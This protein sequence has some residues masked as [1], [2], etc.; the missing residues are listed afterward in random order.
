MYVNI[1]YLCVHAEDPDYKDARLFTDGSNALNFM[2]SKGDE[3]KDWSIHILQIKDRYSCM[4]VGCNG[5]LLHN[6][7][8]GSS[9]QVDSIEWYPPTMQLFGIEHENDWFLISI[10]CS[11]DTSGFYKF[12]FVAERLA[13]MGKD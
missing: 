4:M 8:Y 9:L 10:N 12:P 13:T 6:K 1:L 3:M 2:T 11:E 7:V 5:L